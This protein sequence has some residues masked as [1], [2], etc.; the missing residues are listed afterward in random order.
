MEIKTL[1]ED[2]WVSLKSVENDDEWGE[3]SY[4]FSH[5]TR[6]KGEIVAILP[7]RYEKDDSLT[8]LL[9]SEIVPCWG[10]DPCIVSI[11]GG[12]ED[13]APAL[14]AM[15][16]LEEEAGLIVTPEEL[17]PLGACRGTKSTD[18]VY[19]LFGVDATGKVRG[20]AK[21]DGSYLEK[22]AHCFWSKNV[23]DAVDPLVFTMLCRLMYLLE[24]EW[25][26]RVT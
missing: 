8:F 17:I 6:C 24:Y 9:R 1:F 3:G 21:G 18:T 10:F 13:N 16:E 22:I 15:H 26:S 20:E 25:D 14:T 4:T 19:H 23:H 5:E 11:T 12:V 2:A 7:F